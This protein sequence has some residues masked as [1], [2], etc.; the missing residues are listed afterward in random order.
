ML[1]SSLKAFTNLGYFPPVTCTM[2]LFAPPNCKFLLVLVDTY[3]VLSHGL[4]HKCNFP[5][6]GAQ[7]CSHAQLW[8]PSF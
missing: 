7:Y 4:M 2:L 1:R 8:M 6:S 5:A 3:P